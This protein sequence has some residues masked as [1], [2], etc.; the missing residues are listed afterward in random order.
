MT[1]WILVAGIFYTALFEALLGNLPFS[2]R[3]CTV[4]YFS[5]VLAFRSLDFITPIPEGKHNIAADVWQFD[6]KKDPNLL[7]HPQL[8]TCVTVLL[9]ASFLFSLVAAFLCSRR[10]FYVKTPERN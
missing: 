2:I 5:R 9:A 7:E 10:E 3:M 1:R 8:W 4:I 6:L